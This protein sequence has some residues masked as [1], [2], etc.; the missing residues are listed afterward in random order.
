MRT[1]AKQG[2]N[3]GGIAGPLEA[4]FTDDGHALGSQLGLEL[5]LFP[6]DLVVHGLGRRL[7]LGLHGL[8]LVLL[9]ADLTDEG[10]YL[11]LLAL[12]PGFGVRL[13]LPGFLLGGAGLLQL[14][15]LLLDLGLGGQQL[16]HDGV[17][18]GHDFLHH[19]EAVQHVGEILRVEEDGPIGDLPLLL[20]IAHPLT[21][22]LILLRLLLLQLSQFVLLLGDQLVIFGDLC[23]DVV[24]LRLDH[25][26]L[27]LQQAL[28]FQ[29]LVLVGG[30]GV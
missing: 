15:L 20:H 24:D 12:Q 8:Q 21:E 16:V 22:E 28:L 7:E 6:G 23:V 29:C 11:R 1:A 30:D 2:G 26:D 4:L 25:V 5:P 19:H 13:L 18:I 3:G 10:V 17:V 14:R 9:A 27:L